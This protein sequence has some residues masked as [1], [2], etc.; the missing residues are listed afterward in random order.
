MFPVVG[1]TVGAGIVEA[2]LEPGGGHIQVAV[3]G[4]S[5]HSPGIRLDFPAAQ[6]ARPSAGPRPGI[7]RVQHNRFDPV[8]ES[9]RT[10]LSG[11]ER[12]RH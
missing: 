9:V 2:A 6:R 5:E 4:G 10:V 3:L 11:A 7:L 8:L 1:R 12:R